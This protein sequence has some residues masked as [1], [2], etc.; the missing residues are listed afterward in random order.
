MKKKYLL[1]VSLLL[2]LIS[3]KQKNDGDKHLGLWK[4][5]KT[6]YM[7]VTKAGNKGYFLTFSAYHEGYKVT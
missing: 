6:Q 3:C 7:N 4:I 5:E 2:I 1:L